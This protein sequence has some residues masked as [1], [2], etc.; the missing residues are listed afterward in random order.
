MVSV[1]IGFQ[2][3][4]GFRAVAGWVCS[5]MGIRFLD[6]SFIPCV[7]LALVQ[8]HTLP[9]RWSESALGVCTKRPRGLRKSVISGRHNSI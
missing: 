7:F 2:G 6:F 5:V 8:G 9:Y 3:L 4:G 1:I